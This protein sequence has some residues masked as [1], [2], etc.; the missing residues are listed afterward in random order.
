MNSQI[1]NEHNIDEIIN[2]L[3][4]IKRYSNITLVLKLISK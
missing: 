1:S 3:L 2:K 4:D